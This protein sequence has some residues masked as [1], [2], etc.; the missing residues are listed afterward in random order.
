[1]TEGQ[2]Q[3][4]SDVVLLCTGYDGV[5]HIKKILPKSYSDILTEEGNK[6]LQL[7]RGVIHPHI[8]EIAFLGFHEG[9]SSVQTSEMGSRWLSK[10][11]SGKFSLPSV[12]EM[13]AD[14][15]LWSALKASTSSFSDRVS[16]VAP[17]HTWHFDRLCKD[18][19]WD[20]M[21][22]KGILQNWFSP[23]T[24][25]DYCEIVDCSPG[26]LISDGDNVSRKI[27]GVEEAKVKVKLV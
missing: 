24:N 26:R 23:Y 21:R 19:G 10:L 6:S 16:C 20:P 4:E 7:Y 27:E 8:P 9:L 25:A 2:G 22:R 13:D 5:G 12:K 11:L 18:M 3:W 1:M 17:L 14:R 15:E